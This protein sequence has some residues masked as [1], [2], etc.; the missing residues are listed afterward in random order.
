MKSNEFYNKCIYFASGAAQANVSPIDLCNFCIIIP[1][2]SV[3]EKY[4]NIANYLISNYCNN[5]QQI[6]TLTSLRDYL[7]PLLMNGQVEVKDA[8]RKFRDIV[9]EVRMAAEPEV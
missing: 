3:L 6:Q 7:L 2:G 5:Q 8:E 9:G 4:N 1:Q